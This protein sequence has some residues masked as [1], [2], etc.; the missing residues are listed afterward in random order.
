MTS[1]SVL[2]VCTG[3]RAPGADPSAPRPGAALL[4]VVRA[5]SPV[6]GAAKVEGITCLSGCKRH[7]AVA[8][9]APGRVTYLFGDLAPDA[10]TAHALLGAADA[11]AAAPDGWLPRAERPTYLRTNIL[12]RIPP[13]HWLPS[14]SDGPIGWPT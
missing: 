6:R 4:Q 8:L 5:V 12:A 9:I 14:A 3:C 10:S 2:L 7:C 1:G 11:H 13:L